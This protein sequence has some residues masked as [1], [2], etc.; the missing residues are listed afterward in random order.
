MHNVVLAS[1]PNPSSL[2]TLRGLMSLY[3]RSGFPC[4]RCST[5]ITPWISSYRQFSLTVG[6]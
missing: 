1:A 3:V 5:T 4:L 2:G 6:Q